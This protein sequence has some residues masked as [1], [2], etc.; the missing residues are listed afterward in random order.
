MGSS[1]KSTLG[2]PSRMRR[3]S[4][5]RRSPGEPRR[6]PTTAGP[7]AAQHRRAGQI[8]SPLHRRKLAGQQAQERRL[9][10]AI[11]TDQ[12]VP[13]GRQAQRDG[14]KQRRRIGISH[15]DAVQRAQA[16]NLL[17]F[18]R[19]DERKDWAQFE[20]VRMRARG[21]RAA[22][23]LS[24]SRRADSPQHSATRRPLRARSTC[25]PSP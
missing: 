13:T 4:A 22:Q 16:W 14:R 5:R 3:S 11:G 25:G 17:G 1:N 12:S 24:Q 23:E 18:E 10:R 6:P 8:K 20:E 21:E 9:A 2:C 15:R 7:Q 19:T